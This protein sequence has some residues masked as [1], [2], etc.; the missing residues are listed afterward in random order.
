MA[1][2]ELADSPGGPACTSTTGE[3]VGTYT[4]AEVMDNPLNALAWLANHLGTRGLALK[5]G[6]CRHVR[7]HLEDV[8]PQGRRYDSRHVHAPGFGRHH[9]R[10]REAR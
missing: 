4:A 3:I 10:C 7:G 9:G 2:L 8:T 1:A 5:P 6:D